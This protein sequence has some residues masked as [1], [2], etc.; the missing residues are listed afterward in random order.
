[1]LVALPSPVHAAMPLVAIG[2]AVVVAG[3]LVAALRDGR[4]GARSWAGIGLASAVVVCGHAMTFLIAARAA[5]VSAPPSRMVPL[6][7]LAMLVM[8]LPSIGGWGPREGAT[9]WAFGAAGL[10]AQ[11]GV[12][13]AVAYGV[14]VLVSTLP[15]AAVLVISWLRRRRIP[16]LAEPPLA[17]HAAHA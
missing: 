4:L 14:M 11:L 15:G 16:E 7:L 17:K 1:V 13:T 6:A 3:L 2:V 9:A 8:V 10:G 12:A 5:G